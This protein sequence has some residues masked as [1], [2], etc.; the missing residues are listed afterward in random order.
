MT[1]LLDA[2]G[3]PLAPRPPAAAAPDGPSLPPDEQ[4]G[5][6][7]AREI[8]E[9]RKALR[10]L[11]AQLTRGALAGGDMITC[12]VPDLYSFVRVTIAALDAFVERRMVDE[13]GVRVPLAGSTAHEL[14]TRV[15][16]MVATVVT[17]LAASKEAAAQLAAQGTTPL[18]GIA[19]VAEG[20]LGALPRDAASTLQAVASSERALR[21]GHHPG[22]PPHHG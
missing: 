17:T 2:T 21:E 3:Q 19:V 22:L 8:S 7:T 15:A 11:Q 12:P 14:E 13:N 4:A 6:D 1:P 20:A 5:I 16:E 9:V 10:A 18:A